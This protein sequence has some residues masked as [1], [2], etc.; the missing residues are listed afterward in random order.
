MEKRI[1]LPL[2]VLRIDKLATVMSTASAKAVSVMWRRAN[3]SSSLMMIMAPL[4]NRKVAVGFV[5][6]GRR[7]QLLQNRQEDADHHGNCHDGATN[8]HHARRV[9]ELRKAVH[10]G[11]Q[12][13][14]PTAMTP[15][16]HFSSINKRNA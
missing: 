2:P 3:S 13:I 7:P 15:T 10:Q 8:Q 14:A 12:Q 11:N 4:L 1:A 16:A 5:G 9:V 6:Q